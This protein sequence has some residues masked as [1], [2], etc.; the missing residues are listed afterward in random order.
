M[1]T[2]VRYLLLPAAS[3]RLTARPFFHLH[4]QIL[5]STLLITHLFLLSSPK[6]LKQP[7][8]IPAMYRPQLP[9]LPVW[10]LIYFITRRQLPQ[11][12]FPHPLIVKLTVAGDLKVRIHLHQ[13]MFLQRK[14][15]CCVNKKL[16]YF[17][18]RLLSVRIYLNGNLFNFPPHFLLLQTFYG[19]KS[20]RSDLNTSID[21]EKKKLFGITTYHH[22]PCSK[23]RG[24]SFFVSLSPFCVDKIDEIDWLWLGFSLQSPIQNDITRITRHKIGCYL[25]SSLSY[26]LVFLKKV[27][28][29]K[30]KRMNRKTMQCWIIHIVSR[31]FEVTFFG[32]K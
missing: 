16:L 30:H 10:P 32:G 11:R 5:V 4:L 13:R 14:H 22:S 17:S 25:H 3:A 1:S 27:F 19:G 23:G 12:L 18:K 8:P 26:I 20:R 7:R 21:R 9:I 15:F 24:A 31:L 2:V 6:R 28:V 29:C